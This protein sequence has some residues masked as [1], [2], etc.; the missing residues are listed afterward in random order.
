MLTLG[1]RL[2]ATVPHYRTRLP[3]VTIATLFTVTPT[4]INRRI[5]D[6]R[7]LL[8]ATGY[9]ITPTGQRLTSLEALHTFAEA[10]G[11]ERSNPRVN[12]LRALRRH[13]LHQFLQ[14]SDLLTRPPESASVGRRLQPPSTT[15]AAARPQSKD[16]AFCRVSV[17]LR[18]QAG[19]AWASCRGKR[20]T[21]WVTRERDAPSVGS[22]RPLVFEQL[23]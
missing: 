4:T 3:Q 22:K 20:S 19:Y 15:I 6:I 18:C 17:Y 10:P 13:R 5:R 1:D 21:S 7:Q 16:R 14:V 9:T 11:I 23:G 8:A 12:D 2:L